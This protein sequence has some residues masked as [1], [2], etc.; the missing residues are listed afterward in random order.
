VEQR[1]LILCN[2]AAIPVASENPE[3]PP[4]HSDH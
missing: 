2:Q 4:S 3:C 1:K